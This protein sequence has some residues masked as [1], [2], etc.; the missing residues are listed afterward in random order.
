MR[1][2]PLCMISLLLV[3]TYS[4]V[5]VTGGAKFV[6]E[7]R[8]SGIE[9]HVPDGEN[10]QV[11]GEVYQKEEKE[12]YQI[13]YLKNNSVNYQEQSFKESKLIIYDEKKEKACI[14]NY[15]VAFGGVSIYQKERNPGNFNQKLYYQKQGISAMVWADSIQVSEGMCKKKWNCVKEQLYQF[16]NAWKQQLYDAMGEENG[17]ILTAML[18]G[19]K[20]DMDADTIELYQRNG[21]GHILAIS[22]LHLS[23]IG[24]GLYRMIRRVTGSYTVGG[25]AGVLFLC[26]YILMIG[27]GVS[28][29]RAFVMF[30]FRVGADMVGRKYD[31]LTALS[32]A[33]SVVLLWRPL[34]LY[35]GGFW[36]SFGAVL[37]VLIVLPMFRKLPVQAFW[38]S[39]SIN[40]VLFPVQ[41]YFFYEFPIYSLLLNLWVI[42]LM[43]AVLFL[44][45]VG[46][47]TVGIGMPGQLLLRLC[48]LIFFIYEKSCEAAMRMPGACVVTGQLKLW[49][50]VV[51][52]ALLILAVLLGRRAWKIADKEKAKAVRLRRM[53][54]LVAVVAVSVIPLGNTVRWRGNL[55]ITMM[56]VGQGDGIFLRSPS[57]NAYVI[58][59]GSSDVEQVG[60]YRM[61][62]F[63]ESQGV[64]TIEYLLITHGDE[65]HTKGWIE[66]IDDK[67]SIVNIETIIFPT[68]EVWD[69]NLYSLAR[70][71]EQRNIKVACM[72]KGSIIS[73]GELQIECLGP[74]PEYSGDTGN[75]ASLLLRVNYQGFDML[76]TGDVED[77]GEE[78][79]QEVLNRELQAVSWEA[80]KIAHHGSKNSSSEELL[81]QI[82]PTY[83]LI[84]AGQ[85]NRYGHPH[86]ETL[87]RLERVGSQVFT[88]KEKGAITLVTDGEKMWIKTYL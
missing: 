4:A 69:E 37:A 1:H 40:F 42:P 50:I 53:G 78:A 82:Q 48:N 49:Q 58:D 14:G 3:L 27:V 56:D 31:S 79:L 6:K 7:L 46:S 30:L 36:L 87:E 72:Q 19:E 73:D 45:I 10:I 21:I 29:V 68:K 47:I 84:S 52:E 75:A 85:E 86:Q 88:T 54:W 62:P 76:F 59:G 65:D 38:A 15:I 55:Q 81:E 71:A 12:D 25:I 17:A 28:V 39:V 2:R 23:V 67:N 34:Y 11:A 26:S 32:V 9:V 80:L 8:P 13:L 44:G 16:R 33:A 66:L 35:D 61:E 83:A 60:K 41:C 18:L 74:G 20:G 51:Y 24:V 57:G 22:G 5:I 64:Q 43:S 70:K 77:E 63:L